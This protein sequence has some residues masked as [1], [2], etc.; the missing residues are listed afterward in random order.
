MY[1]YTYHRVYGM[2]PQYRYSVIHITGGVST[3]DVVLSITTG[4]LVVLAYML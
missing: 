2:Y 4:G 1:V 3:L